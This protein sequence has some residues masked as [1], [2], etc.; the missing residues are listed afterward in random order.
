MN[1]PNVLKVFMWREC[2]NVL[3]TKVNLMKR[4][5][6]E[7]PLCPICGLEG[8]TTGHILWGCQVIDTRCME[9]V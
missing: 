3:P 6:V 8:E 7:D 2:N 5:I 9:C 1:V 4:K